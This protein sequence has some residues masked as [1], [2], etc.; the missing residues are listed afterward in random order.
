MSFVKVLP[1]L[2]K[3]TGY[4]L[5]DVLIKLVPFIL[6]PLFAHLLT[7]QEFKQVSLYIVLISFLLTILPMG[8]PSK[9]LLHLTEKHSNVLNLP[10]ALIIPLILFVTFLL[11]SPF[12]ASRVGGLTV[13]MILLIVI[14]FNLVIGQSIAV[15]YQAE[16]KSYQFGMIMLALQLCFYVPLA[17]IVTFYESLVFLSYGFIFSI[18]LQSTVI[19]LV[20]YFE[21]K[22]TKNR[23]RFSLSD[24]KIYYVF[25]GSVFIH[26][27]VN[28]IRFV[29][30][31]LFMASEVSD[32]NF[33]YYNVAMQAAMILSV[34]MVSCNRFWSSYFFS[35]RSVTY[36]KYFVCILVL[37]SISFLVYGFGYTYISYFF[38]Q[39]YR[40]SL[41]IL[42]IL[43][44]G[45]FF[46][47]LYL[48]F[49]AR[50]YVGQNFWAIN[51]A[52]L[53]SLLVVL[54]LMPVFFEQ[55]GDFGVALSIAL[56]WAALLITSV[57]VSMVNRK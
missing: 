56:S 53:V 4:I 5:F 22:S 9:I 29:Y 16:Q 48:I 41:V 33:T 49:S 18:L 36:A 2:K 46:Q 27:A 32:E 42:P 40:A 24:M 25:I 14:G 20:L 44:I 45:F 52:S 7:V 34:L 31:R 30:D 1:Q 43:I 19:S 10:S 47:G 6:L 57:F 50:L 13:E 21:R 11:T 28:A 55:Y 3:L 39:E 12:V 38:P 23:I 17:A 26:I 54:L 51:S 15:R 35:S 8:V 37:L